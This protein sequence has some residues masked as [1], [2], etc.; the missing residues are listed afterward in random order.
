MDNIAYQPPVT[1]L[2]ED[3]RSG[4]HVSMKMK[5]VWAVQI[6]LL[7]QL[8]RTC[9]KYGLTY[10]ADSGTLLGAIRHEGFIP[11]DDDI[12]IVMK[13]S[14]YNKLIEIADDEFLFPYFLQSAHSEVFPR[15]YARL[16]NSNTTAL[17][18]RDLGKPINHGIFIDIFPVDN[19]PDDIKVR[20]AWIKKIVFLNK[21]INAGTMKE[22]RN[23]ELLR[24]RVR[25]IICRLLVKM[26]GYNEM[27]WQYEKLC[28]KYNNIKTKSISYVAYSQ[29]KQK[30]IWDRV[31]YDSYHSV[32][33]EYTTINIPDGYDSR[34]RVEYGEYMKPVR[35]GTFHGEVI[36]EPD[37]PFKDYLLN[38]STEEISKYFES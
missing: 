5:K 38:H 37:I 35:A 10:F 11:W 8:K 27:V 15:G 26:I 21:I 31:C 2:V 17:T 32:P 20:T 36:L 34:L 7:E 6:D 13:R 18:K 23:S 3:D 33:F 28:S 4:Y 22:I 1:F 19:I 24:D 25:I 14:D 12:D 30:H 9:K 29:G 16:R